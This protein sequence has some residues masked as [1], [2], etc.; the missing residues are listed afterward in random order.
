MSLLPQYRVFGWTGLSVRIHRRS[1]LV[2]GLLALSLFCILALS[3]VSGGYT[4]SATDAWNVLKGE[5]VSRL[6]DFFVLQRRL[7]RALLAATVGACLGLSGNLFQAVTRNPLASPDVI[8]VTNGAS[9]GAAIVLLLL[10]GSFAQASLGALA[11]AAVTAALMLLLASRTGLTG[12]RFIIFGIALGALSSAVVSY[13]MTQVYVGNAATAQMWLLGSLQGR[14][15]Q[16][17]PLAAWGLVAAFLLVIYC[18]KDML[19]GELGEESA[20]SLGANVRRSRA[21]LILAGILAVAAA[22]VSAG[23]I[24]FVALAAPH[25]AQRLGGRAS[26]L[27]SALC[28]GLLLAVCD[29][30]ALYAF[31]VPI[32]VG[33]VTIAVGG[34]FFLYLLWREGAVRSR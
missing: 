16:E 23:A 29:L 26:P 5:S 31:P 11:G 17:L 14:G 32:P 12:S 10:G 24:S 4:V 28:G 34:A 9:A 27:A 6:T 7:P 22:I 3:L 19:L 1:L 13:L 8:G 25:I 30:I 20:V 21:L 2:I 33:A 18:R 15:W